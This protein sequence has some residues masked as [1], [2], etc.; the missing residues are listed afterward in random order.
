MRNPRS[1]NQN[2]EASLTGFTVLHTVETENTGKKYI[3]ALEI[4]FDE[5]LTN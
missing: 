4:R 2:L 3:L 1:N 5:D